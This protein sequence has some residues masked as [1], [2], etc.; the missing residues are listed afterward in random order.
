MVNQMEA[1]LHK[2][3]QELYQHQTNC[4]RFK[5]GME[6]EKNRELDKQHF[7]NLYGVEFDLLGTC[8]KRMEDSERSLYKLKH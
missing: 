8:H 5:F 2:L 3:R 4:V 1:S 7:R 6:D